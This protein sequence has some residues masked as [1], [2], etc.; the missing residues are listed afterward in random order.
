MLTLHPTYHQTSIT[1]VR[2]N[3]V[4]SNQEQ[5]K[6]ETPERR[7]SAAEM[8]NEAMVSH[9]NRHNDDND[10]EEEIERSKT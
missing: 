3:K 5:D 1:K 8:F 10:D 9:F 6:N 7:K 2:D 4:I